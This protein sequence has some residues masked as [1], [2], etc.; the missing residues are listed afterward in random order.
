MNIASDIVDKYTTEQIIAYL[1]SVA[2]GL[3]L[4]YRTAIKSNQPHVLF[5]NMGD[6]SQMK[7]ILHEMR[8]RNDTQE[9]LKKSVVK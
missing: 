2:G 5:G 8:K 3:L 1:D 9:A 6:I 4:N 7:E